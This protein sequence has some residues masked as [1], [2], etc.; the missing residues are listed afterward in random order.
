MN[1]FRLIDLDGTVESFGTDDRYSFNNA[2]LLVIDQVD[3]TR[4]IYAASAWKR[5]ETTPAPSQRPAQPP[6]PG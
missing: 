6:Q 3:G 5:I 2:G 1:G 4:R